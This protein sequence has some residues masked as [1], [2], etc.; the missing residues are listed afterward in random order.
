MADTAE[1]AVEYLYANN[2]LS[3]IQTAT[4]DYTLTHDAFGNM[5]S[6]KAGANTLATYD[7]AA[8]NGKLAQPRVL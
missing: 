6:I 1:P 2:R 8:N 7:Y 3:G 4:T 5:L